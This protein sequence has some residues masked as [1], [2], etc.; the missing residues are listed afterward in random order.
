MQPRRLLAV[1]LPKPHDDA[2]LIRSHREG[3]RE[4]GDHRRHDDGT[5]EKEWTGYAG[6]PRHD[7]FQPVLASL[8]EFFQIGLLVRTSGRA[9]APRAATPASLTTTPTLVAPR[10]SISPFRCFADYRG[11]LAGCARVRMRDPDLPTR[12]SGGISRISCL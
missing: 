8:E 4:I 9:L 2:Q 1:D 3:E 7:L 12:A 10:H 6:A 11:A 5:Q